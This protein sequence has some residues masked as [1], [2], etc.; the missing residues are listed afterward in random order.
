MEKQNNYILLIFLFFLL[1]SN[2]LSRF[3]NF[4]G[5]N[6][7]FYA[8]FLIMFY[9][10]FKCRIKEK[11]NVWQF[12]LLLIFLFYILDP[13]YDIN[14]NLLTVKDFIIPILALQI[15]YYFALKKDDLLN[16]LNILFFIFVAYA[17]LQEVS[18]YFG[19]LSEVLPWDVNYLKKI[20]ETVDGALNYSQGGLLRF[21]GAMNAFVECQIY[22]VVI[23][24]FLSL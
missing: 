7:A 10:S 21:F 12:L 23:C 20:A 22:I 1:F 13:R 14:A 6:I 11:L 5:F 17:L 15:G 24:L 4:E 2:L 18:F 8:I 9:E 19:I 3:F 16:K